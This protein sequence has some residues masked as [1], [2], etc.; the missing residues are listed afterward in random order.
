MDA[1]VFINPIA[2]RFIRCV[3]HIPGTSINAGGAGWNLQQAIARCESELVERSYE[4]HELW[5]VGIH[6]AGIAAHNNLE[7]ALEKAT[8]EAVET[9]CLDHIYKE[10][11]IRCHYR[12]K[13]GRTTFGITRTSHGYFCLIQGFL[14]DTPIAG[15][16]AARNIFAALI[17]AWEEF[18]SIHYFKPARE[19]LKS[20]SKAHLLFSEE[21]LSSLTFVTD[22]HH[23]Y[24]FEIS[25]L[26]I[27]KAERSGKV[28]AYLY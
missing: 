7:L 20:F 10:K 4:V 21:E 16:T 28:I 24:K 5:P 15:Y 12:F 23:S 3:T 17:K 14:K 1:T 25:S 2:L 6:P 27:D 11:R 8:Q 26:K 22:Q 9:F 18:Q 19:R 13:V